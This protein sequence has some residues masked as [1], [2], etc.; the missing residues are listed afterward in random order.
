MSEKVTPG[1]ILASRFVFGAQQFQEYID[2]ID[3]PEAVRSDAYFLY[4]VYTEYMDNPEKQQR[5]GLNTRSDRA[6]ALFTATKDNLTSAEKQELKEQFE[7][8]QKAD[9]PMW[10]NVISFT[11]EFLVQ[12]GMYDKASGLLDEEKMRTVTRLAMAEMLK[13]EHMEASAVW[14]ASIHYNTDNIHVHIAVVEP[15]PTRIKKEI[16]EQKEDGTTEKKVQFRGSLRPSTFQKMKSKVVNNIVNRQPELTMIND[17][18]RKSIVSE[19]RQWQASKDEKLRGAFINLYRQLPENRRFWS[20]NMNALLPVRPQIDQ[21]SKLYIDLY[22]REDF[23]ELTRK[24]E[25]QEK[26]LQSVYGSGKQKLYKNY[27]STKLQDLYTRMGNAVL[28]ELREYDKTVRAERSLLQ[29]K[30]SARQKL[31][32]KGALA[33]QRSSTEYSL[34]KAFRKDYMEAKNLMEFE[35]LQQDIDRENDRQ[36]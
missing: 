26:Y 10:Q 27:A 12:N 31:T 24:L 17:I 3:R 25:D 36:V 20:Y 19:K 30:M 15:I 21:F 7:K 6:A 9:S 33:R 16:L 28:R 32:E 35:H 8:A 34:K 22:H 1:V 18:I 2:Y 23:A 5:S 29:K 13:N 11:T 4:S 14:S